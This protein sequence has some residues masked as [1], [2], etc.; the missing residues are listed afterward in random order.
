M[1]PI[2]G[3]VAGLWDASVSTRLYLS[4]VMSLRCNV[5]QVTQTVY[6][7]RQGLSTEPAATPH[8]PGALVP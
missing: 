5:S 4:G 1:L 3:A 2:A 8:S 6:S 7:V